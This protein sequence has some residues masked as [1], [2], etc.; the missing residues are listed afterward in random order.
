MDHAVLFSGDSDFRR[1]VEAVQRKGVRVSVV[2]SIRTSPPM[3]A[4]ELRRQADQFLELAEIA[5]EFTRRQTEP[6]TRGT[7]M[8]G[9]PART[10]MP[11]R[12]TPRERHQP[13][14]TS[15]RRTAPTVRFAP[16]WS[17]YRD[18]NRM[19]NP[20]W[21]NGAVAELRSDRGASPGRRP[22]ARRAR[23]QSHRTAVHRRFR[24]GFAVS[25][26]AEIR[27]GGGRYGADPADGLTLNDCRVTNAVRC[28]PPANLPTPAEIT[29]C[30]PF[31]SNELAA[32]PRLRARAGTGRR[33]A[34]GRA[35]GTR[36]AGE[37]HGV[38]TRRDPRLARR[39][40]GRRQLPRLPPQHE[41]RP[42]DHANVRGRGRRDRSSAWRDGAKTVV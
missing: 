25:D 24:R 39:V 37:L 2:S 34:Q 13:G 12:T 10:L 41:Y 19:N 32:M 28:V 29:A 21:H 8:R 1:L 35:A 38:S 3:V 26:A 9:T 42:P 17:A 16:A 18:S 6:R 14:H 15:G 11:I 5:P 22:G 7:V 4:D 30:N 36:P 33:V 27:P 20:T 23:R 31:L 40:A